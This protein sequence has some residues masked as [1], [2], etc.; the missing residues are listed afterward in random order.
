LKIPVKSVERRILL[1]AVIKASSLQILPSL[2]AFA[3]VFVTRSAGH[4]SYALA[5]VSPNVTAEK[6]PSRDPRFSN[7]ATAA[8]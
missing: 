1:P 2:A 6:K 8:P 3:L 7:Q 4:G 5:Q